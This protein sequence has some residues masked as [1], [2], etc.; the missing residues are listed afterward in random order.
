MLGL[1]GNPVSAA[2]T[3]EL[4]ARPAIRKML[5]SNQLERPMVEVELEGEE[6]ERADRRHFVRAHLRSRQGVLA[7][8]PTGSQ[9]SHRIAS[10]QGATALLVVMEGE[11]T[12]RIGDHLPALLLNDASMPWG[13]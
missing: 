11:G 1:P 2:V 8:T 13:R 6:L 3:F 9:A 12:I 4:F 10:L 5:G 7:A